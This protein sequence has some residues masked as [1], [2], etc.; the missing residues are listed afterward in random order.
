MFMPSWQSEFLREHY[1]RPRE[2][3]GEKNGRDDETRTR[4]SA[5]T[6]SGLQVLSTTWKNTA[7]RHWKYVVHN[8]IVYRD[9][10]R[11]G[12]SQPCRTGE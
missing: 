1:V 7:L 3:I 4:E 8:V 5:V 11:E 2:N 6:V 12:F 9:V 10:Y